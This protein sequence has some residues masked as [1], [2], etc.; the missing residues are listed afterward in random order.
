MKVFDTSVL[1]AAFLEDHPHHAP[2][3]KLFAQADRAHAGCAAHSL[4]EVYSVLTR[5][6]ADF[7]LSADQALLFI[8][9][10][11]QRLKLVTLDAGEYYSAISAAANTGITIGGIYDAL[12]VECALKAGAERIFN[13]NVRD[14]QR[15]GPDVA[16]R[17][18]TP[19]TAS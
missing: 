4:A 1:I 17:V 9:D 16:K 10:V 11:R 6:P 12:L 8:G 18:R 15:L 19:D 7:R 3:H 13:W 5:L 2:S 14:F